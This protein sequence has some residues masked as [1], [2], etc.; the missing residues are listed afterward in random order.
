[1]NSLGFIRNEGKENNYDGRRRKSITQL[2][3]DDSQLKPQERLYRQK[4]LSKQKNTNK[5]KYN[6]HFYS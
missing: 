4:Q 2:T 3:L 1:M 5:K 6:A